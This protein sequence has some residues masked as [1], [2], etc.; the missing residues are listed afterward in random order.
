M[1]STP[2]L[3]SFAADGTNGVFDGIRL[4]DGHMLT[5]NVRPGAATA[6]AFLCAGLTAPDTEAW[7]N[8]ESLEEWLTGGDAGAAPTYLDVPIEAVREL[9]AQHGG[10]H[11]NQEQ[12][13]PDTETG[14]ETEN[15]APVL[16]LFAIANLRGRFEDGY[17][18]DGIRSV[19]GRIYDEGGPYLVCVWE[20]ADEYG[21]GGSSQ[22]YAE[23]ED[24]ALFEVQPAIHQWLSGQQEAPGPVAE[25]ICAPAAEP[26]EFPVSDDFHNYAWTDRTGGERVTT[27][28]LFTVEGTTY[29]PYEALP[30]SGGWWTYGPISVTRATAE[31]IAED[32][33]V[34]DAG[35]GL[36]AEWTGEDLVFTWGESFPNMEDERFAPDAD[37]R[38]LIGG[39]W[40]WIGVQAEQAK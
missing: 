11:E 7:E 5:L 34:R 3:D 25:W 38:Y 2:R 24:G 36:T 30:V 23:D 26:T 27:R 33:N 12:P 39:L 8:E 20:Y 13:A 35:C 22:F 10:E 19:F 6:E 17:S 4:A 14:K 32:L 21:F 40:P 18:A 31:Q 1:T 37:G 29:G 16:D 9:I 15:D 28:H